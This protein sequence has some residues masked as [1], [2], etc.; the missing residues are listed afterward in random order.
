MIHIHRWG[1]WLA[2]YHYRDTSWS[3]SGV[4]STRMVRRCD[5]CG[6]AK[7]KGLYGAMLPLD[8]EAGK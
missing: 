4:P 7:S 8:S 3:K 6:A 2:D 5:R 1:K